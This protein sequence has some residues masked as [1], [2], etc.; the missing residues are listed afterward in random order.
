[1]DHQDLLARDFK[2]AKPSLS[3]FSFVQLTT[4]PP[5]VSSNSIGCNWNLEKLHWPNYFF[6][7]PSLVGGWFTSLDIKLTLNE[8]TGAATE[9]IK[10]SGVTTSRVSYINTHLQ[11]FYQLDVWWMFCPGSSYSVP[12]QVSHFLRFSIL[13]HLQPKNLSIWSPFGV[14]TWIAGT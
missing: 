9:L 12:W 7:K 10:S 3:V 5:H 6:S 8:H 11:S 13:N 2:G 4:P 14:W 1:M